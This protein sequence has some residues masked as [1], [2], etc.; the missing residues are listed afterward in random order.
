M[1]PQKSHCAFSSISES[2]SECVYQVTF[3]K[4]IKR[5]D[6][7]SAI[8]P[9]TTLQVARLQ[10]VSL[11]LLLFSHSVMSNSLQPH[12]LQ[13]ARPLCPQDFPGKNIGVGCHFLIQGI[14]PI[15]ELNPHPLHLLQADSLPLSC[16]GSLHEQRSSDS[17]II[18]SLP[19]SENV[20]D[21]TD[22]SLSLSTHSSWSALFLIPQANE[23][24]YSFEPP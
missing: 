19:F 1:D 18:L 14:F 5:K 8:A 3:L 16:L 22:H 12:G 20:T 2:C 21:P 6:G 13:P 23:I 24:Y 15:Q 17:V 7:T 9:R 10:T 11:L 4:V